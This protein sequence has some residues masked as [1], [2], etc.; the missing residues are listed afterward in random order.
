MFKLNAKVRRNPRV[1]KNDTTIFTVIG[2]EG[3]EFYCQRSGKTRNTFTGK[4][5]AHQPMP[6]LASELVAA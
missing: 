4:L 6:Y 1:W 2:V 5:E 3:K